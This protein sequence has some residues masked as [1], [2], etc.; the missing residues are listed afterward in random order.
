[1]RMSESLE[2]CKSKV[3]FILNEYVSTRDSDKQLWLAYLCL[4]HDLKEKIGEGPYR[5]LKKLIMSEDTPTMESIRRIRQKYQENGMYAGNGR[6]TR[7]EE[8]EV[9]KEMMK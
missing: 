4:F 7:L 9:V 2:T 5:E 6:K 3:G 8:A 1:M